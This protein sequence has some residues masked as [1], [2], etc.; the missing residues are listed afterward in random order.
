MKRLIISILMESPFYL[1]LD[2]RERLELFK[3]FL[4]EYQI[5]LEARP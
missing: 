4:E 1:L 5:L 3:L 2:L